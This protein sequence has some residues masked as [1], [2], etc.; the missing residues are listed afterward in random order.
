[1]DSSTGIANFK[2]AAESIREAK[3]SKPED[4][5]GLEYKKWV[6]KYGKSAVSP[7]DK[8]F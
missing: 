5:D 1:M 6:V 4:T 3:D 2:K 7:V 8:G